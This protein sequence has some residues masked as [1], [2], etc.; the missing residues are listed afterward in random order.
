MTKKYSLCIILFTTIILNASSQSITD[1]LK[2]LPKSPYGYCF[3]DVGITDEDLI[4]FDSL[5][6]Q[7]TNQFNQF[8]SLSTLK[9]N[10]E[11]YLYMIG[12]NEKKII[13]TIATCLTNIT[14]LVMHAAQRETAWISL[15]TSTQTAAYDMPRWH[16]DSY[17]FNPEDQNDLHY[18]FV[19]TLIGNSTLFY[20]VPHDQRYTF[21]KHTIEREKIANLC[22]KNMIAHAQRGQGALFMMGGVCQAAMHSE[23][24]IDGNRLFF[25]IV[26]CNN[27][28][29]IELKRRVQAF[30]KDYVIFDY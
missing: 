2:T 25:S 11:K 21:W 15:R 30:I 4:L 1:A 5:D 3:F 22:N 17:Y 29:L 23:P 20:P 6:I 28:Q 13:T 9:D 27:Q 16:I 10:I 24:P 26:P 7:T 14:H 12:S 18:K 19:V 8:G